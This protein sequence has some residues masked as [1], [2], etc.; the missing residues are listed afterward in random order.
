MSQQETLVNEFADV[1]IAANFLKAMRRRVNAK[2][3][4]VVH[5]AHAVVSRKDQVE[6]NLKHRRRDPCFDN[7]YVLR[8]VVL[9]LCDPAPST[10][11]FNFTGVIDMAD[12]VVE[13]A[14]ILQNTQALFERQLD[15][16]N[17]AADAAVKEA[18]QRV[19]Q[20]ND[21]TN[22]LATSL[23]N[24]N[25]VLG[26]ERMVRALDNADKI[27]ASLKLLDSLQQGGNL[28]KIIAA[29]QAK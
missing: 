4:V 14:E 18:K 7:G 10:L 6:M 13:A 3:D 19:S 29:L 25:K 8:S 22:R 11:P 20:L 27:A 15:E 23:N 12:Q 17:N 1:K 2:A 24:L 21:Y 9:D 5:G 16:F 26:D 28:D